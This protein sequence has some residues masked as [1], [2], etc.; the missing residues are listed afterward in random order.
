MLNS[1]TGAISGTPTE[2]GIFDLTGQ[3][4]D[5]NSSNAY[6]NL[7][8]TVLSYPVR[9]GSP[10]TYYLSIQDA[11]DS[12]FNGNIIQIG[13]TEFNEDL[14]CDKDVSIVLKGGYDFNYAHNSSY[15]II[16]GTLTITHGTVKIENLIIK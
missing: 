14:Y 16:N 2:T 9:I 7:S 6:K 12:C 13:A 8:I 15:T 3:V 11:Y 5:S 4:T 10:L 1:S